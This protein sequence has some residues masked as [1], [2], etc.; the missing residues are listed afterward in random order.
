[1]PTTWQMAEAGHRLP[2]PSAG[3][4]G[5]TDTVGSHDGSNLRVAVACARFNEEVTTRLL[6]GAVRALDEHRVGMSNRLVALVPGSFELPLAAQALA[7]SGGFDAVVC[8]GAVVRGRRPTTSSSP[9]SAPPVWPAYSSTPTFLSS[10]ASSRPRTSTRPSNGPAA[11]SATRVT[12]RSR[13]PWRWRTSSG[14][15]RTPAPNCGTPAA[16]ASAVADPPCCA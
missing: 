1:M 15:S 11:L 3:K 16:G 10:S 6:A 13:Q 12:R 8:L 5:R 4:G 2:S 7:H 14:P 9:V